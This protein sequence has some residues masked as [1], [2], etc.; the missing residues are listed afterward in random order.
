M[1]KKV[2]SNLKMFAF[3]NTLQSLLNKEVT[4]PVHIR[5]K[6][7]N[8]CNHDCWYCSYHASNLDLG[9]DMEYRD[10]IPIDKM[11]QIVSDIIRMKVSAVTFSGGGEPLL[12]KKL[13]EIIENLSKGGVKV[14]ALTNGANLKGEMADAFAEYGSWIR[15]SL[16]GY[17]DESYAK[18]RRVGVGEFSKLLNNLADFSA[19]DTKCTLSAVYVVDHHNYNHVFDICEKLKV[20]G[21]KTVKLSGVIVGDSSDENSRYHQPIK[22]QVGKEIEQTK[23]LEDNDFLI[24]DSYHDLDDRMWDKNYKTCPNLLYSPVIAADSKVY[25]CHDKAYTESG[26][27][28]DIS[29]QSFKEFWYSQQN[30]KN[31][32]EFSPSSQCKHHCVA[33]PRN[34]LMHEFLSLNRDH[35]DFT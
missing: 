2:Y 5:I 17:D 35:L 18:A 24:N 9:V 13:P 23:K 29:N 12:Y 10:S 27:L 25:T 34:I 16:D 26:C 20:H 19:R 6:P 28:G 30:R 7:T 33:H 4:A 21:V 11:K 1:Q 32:Y 31:I 14:A 3:S 15:V 8:V 22:D